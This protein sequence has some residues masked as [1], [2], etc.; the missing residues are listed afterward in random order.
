[1]CATIA[2]FVVSFH[3]SG[4]FRFDEISWSIDHPSEL[5]LNPINGGT[6]SKETQLDDTPR[7]RDRLP[8]SKPSRGSNCPLQRKLCSCLLSVCS[9]RFF[10]QGWR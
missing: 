9:W 10:S 8:I 6:T 4:T 3:S 7:F 2:V 5:W 1:M